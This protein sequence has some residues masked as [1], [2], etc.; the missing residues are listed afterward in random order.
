MTDHNRKSY[1][2]TRHNLSN[3]FSTTPQEAT[4]QSFDPNT[5]TATLRLLH[6]SAPA[7]GAE[8]EL[9]PDTGLPRRRRFE[10]DDD[11]LRD[12][13]LIVDVAGT[14]G[15]GDVVVVNWTDLIDVRR[16][17]DRTEVD[18]EAVMA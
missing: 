6:A 11:T 2:C 17:S 5:N 13:F 7:I 15:V 9:D 18:G 16:V 4:L 3:L 14:E 10:L 8:L 1:D 12:E